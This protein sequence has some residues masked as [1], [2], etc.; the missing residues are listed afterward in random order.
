MT[1]TQL[2]CISLLASAFILGAMLIAV[3]SQRYENTAQAE[4]V[5]QQGVFTLL[6][7]TGVNANEEFI[8]VLDTRNER[9][10]AYTQDPRGR[11][12]L[13]ATLSIGEEIEKGLKAAGGSGSSTRRDR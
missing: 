5:V 2:A 11:I 6:S 12:E 1:R 10:L 3:V 13:Y 4:M 8:Y 7:T 9:L